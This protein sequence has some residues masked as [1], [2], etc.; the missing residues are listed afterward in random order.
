MS[1]KASAG[2]MGL[3]GVIVA[4]GTFLPI[5]TAGSDSLSYFD[6]PD[7]KLVLGIG[8]A[9]VVFALV[10]A[11]STSRGLS[12]TMG[13]LGLLAALLAG[14]SVVID[15]QSLGDLTGVSA[16]I[17]IYVALL[18]ALVGLVGSIMAFRA[19]RPAPAAGTAPPPPPPPPPPA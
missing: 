11:F 16:G 5:A 14:A 1:T 18:G 12:I 17:G 2:V 8:G 4:V 3:G 7:G 19:P 10:L 9:M 13:V 15:W 6:T